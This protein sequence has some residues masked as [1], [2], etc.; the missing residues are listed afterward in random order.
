MRQMRFPGTEPGFI[1]VE[2]ELM[3]GEGWY[4]VTWEADKRGLL[5]AN[6]RST[7]GPCTWDEASEIVASVLDSISPADHRS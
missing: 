5:T 2:L 1:R 7:Y 4:V 3:K 6:D